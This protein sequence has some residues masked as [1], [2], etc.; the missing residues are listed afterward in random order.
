M[1]EKKSS[2]LSINIHSCEDL[3]MIKKDFPNSYVKCYLKSKNSDK[4]KNMKR[5]TAVIKNNRCPIF[6]ETLRVK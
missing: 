3:A 6:D 5:K 4:E 2:N 1:Y